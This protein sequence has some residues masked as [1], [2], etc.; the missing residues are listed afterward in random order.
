MIS[1]QLVMYIEGNMNFNEN[2]F[3]L[4]M[5][6]TV[7]FCNQFRWHNKLK[8]SHS[9]PYDLMKTLKISDAI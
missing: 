4:N 2:G 5:M 8:M 3:S 7:S 1:I 6:M 9:I